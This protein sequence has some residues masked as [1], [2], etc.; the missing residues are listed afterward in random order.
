MYRPSSRATSPLQF[1][2]NMSEAELAASRAAVAVAPND[3]SGVPAASAHAAGSD[4]GGVAS[5]FGTL[6]IEQL[7]NYL[8]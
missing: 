8:T 1:F 4:I 3:P 7:M 6:S 5:S 2:F